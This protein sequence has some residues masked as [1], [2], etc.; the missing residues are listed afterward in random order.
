VVMEML[1]AIENRQLERVRA[2]YHPKVEFH[3]QPGLPYGGSFSGPALATM[4]ETFE[5]TWFPLQ[6]TE[7]TRRMNP[8]VLATGDGGR[9]I[10]NYLWRGLDPRGRRFETETLAD[11]QI[12]DG[13]LVRAQMFYFDLGGTIRFLEGVGSARAFA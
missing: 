6:P 3:W 11:Y 1:Q 9:V 5:R 10:V 7:E 4:H 2:L 8:R 12:R 13:R